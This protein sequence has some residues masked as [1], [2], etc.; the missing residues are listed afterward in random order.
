MH[1]IMKLNFVGILKLI[2]ALKQKLEFGRMGNV[3]LIKSHFKEKKV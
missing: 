1:A 2:L 3:L